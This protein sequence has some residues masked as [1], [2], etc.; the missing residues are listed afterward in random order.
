[1]VTRMPP[2]KAG[3]QCRSQGKPNVHVEIALVVM[4]TD[5]LV[6]LLHMITVKPDVCV[7]VN[8]MVKCWGDLHH[9]NEGCE[10]C[11]DMAKERMNRMCPK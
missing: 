10:N 1:M 9:N 11:C 6:H 8:E 7:P 5:K 2:F 3:R 4:C